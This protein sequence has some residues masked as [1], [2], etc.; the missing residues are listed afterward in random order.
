MEGQPHRVVV[1][2]E[3]LFD[4]FPD[5][6]RLGG[7]PF[8]FAYHLHGL[9]LSPLLL[10]RVGEDAR[11]RRIRGAMAAAGLAAEGVQ[12]DPDHPTGWVTVALDGAGGHQFT[13]HR[14]VAYDHLD[15]GEVE[16]AMA[17]AP[18]DLFYFGTLACRAPAS[19]TAI[20]AAAAA[21]PGRRF[22][23]VN[24]RPDCWEIDQVRACLRHATVVKLNDEEVATL[25]PLLSLP[26]GEAAA[27]EALRDRFALEAVI[28]TRGDR[29]AAWYGASGWDTCATPE[30]AVVDTVGAGDAF[31][32]VSA[33][34]LLRGWPPALCLER[35]AALA[36][37]VCTVRGACPEEAEFYAPF[38][39]AFGARGWGLGQDGPSGRMR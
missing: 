12:P 24:L 32:A 36:A 30:V 25:A 18:V 3:V 37:A 13:I 31:A 22:L 29:G 15:L 1:A 5:G 7:A 28:L 6:D 33:L 26:E 9:G 20:L 21:T 4:A 34:G 8:N 19:R 35:A 10:S 11:G 27:V 16:A 39:D 2:G 23:D 38:R 17:A 14:D